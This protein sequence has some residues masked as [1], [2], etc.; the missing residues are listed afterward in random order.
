V[1][2]SAWNP[3]PPEFLYGSGG[4]VSLHFLQPAYQQG[5]VPNALATSTTTA[6]GQTITFSSPHRV[7]PDIALD[8]DPNTGALYG[9][10]FD[11]SGDPY[12][13]A[14]CTPLGG[15]R[16]YCLRRIGGTSLSSPLF[17][18]VLALAAQAH[19]GRLGFVNPALYAIGPSAPGS[20]AAIEDVLPPASPTAVL[21]NQEAYDAAG[22]PILRTSLR[23][24]NS[25]P[26]G[27]SG[28]VIEGAD[29]SLRTTGGYDN[30]T[31]L[32]TPYAPALVAALR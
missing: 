26:V 1:T 28:P 20:H 17:A 9:Q 31:G 14:G 16:E 12:I 13:D 8:G 3:W 11:V 5:V 10:T 32:G 27:T 30:V 7:V 29:T 21:R 19:G 6:S 23:T 22:N 15:G 24:I 2:G 18:G 4:G 25:V